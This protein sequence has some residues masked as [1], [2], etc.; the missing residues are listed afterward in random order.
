LREAG[1]VNGN[2]GVAVTHIINDITQRPG[3]VL[4]V[5]DAWGYRAGSME[6]VAVELLVE[7]TGDT[8]WTAEGVQ[9]AEL[10][11]ANGERL[12]ILRVWQPGP[13]P[14]GS[15][16]PLMVEAEDTPE[17]TRGAFLLKLGEAGGPRTLTVRGETFP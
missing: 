2:N 5:R 3:E 14:P 9:G 17:Q 8:P 4:R 10:V 16:G 11:G 7:N 13:F 1:L 15:W 6:R 12:R